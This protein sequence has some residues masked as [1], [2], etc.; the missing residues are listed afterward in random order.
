MESEEK[1]KEE[2]NYFFWIGEEGENK[3]VAASEFE[4][5]VIDFLDSRKWINK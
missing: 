4:Q 5:F 1:N 2:D 3:K